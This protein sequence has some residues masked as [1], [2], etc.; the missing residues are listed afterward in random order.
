MIARRATAAR[1][2]GEPA[3]PHMR[4][5]AACLV[6]LAIAGSGLRAD[7][8]EAPPAAAVPTPVAS[9]APTTVALAAA[10]FLEGHWLGTVD[11]ALSEEIWTA[12]AGDALLGMWRLVAAGETRVF[13]LLAI[14]ADPES[15]LVLRLRHFDR[16][17]VAREEKD[18]PF[19]LRLAR[20]AEGELTFEGRGADGLL[21]IVYRRDGSDGLVAVL[22]RGAKRDEF[23]Y[24]RK[25]P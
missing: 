8:G 18:A 22:E 20:A 4:P 1:Q 2:A 24:R 10:A 14:G 25:A 9:P 23:R 17:L 19:E 21:R 11:G 16:R 5:A 3:A 15:G 7:A 6:A 13:E 12:P